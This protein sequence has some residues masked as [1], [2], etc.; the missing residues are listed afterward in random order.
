M[1]TSNDYRK[2]ITLLYKINFTR[3]LFS[4][5]LWLFHE[6]L[7]RS[8]GAYEK[9]VSRFRKIFAQRVLRGAVRKRGLR[10]DHEKRFRIGRRAGNA[11][12]DLREHGRG[13]GR[14]QALGFPFAVAALGRVVLPEGVQRG[15]A[16]QSAPWPKET[17]VPKFQQPRHV[18]IRR[19][20]SIPPRESGGDETIE[21]LRRRTAEEVGFRSGN[22]V[23][24]WL[25][26]VY[27]FF[28][29]LAVRP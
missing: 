6:T 17:F 27:P 29:L 9:L 28:N 5:Q 23:Y 16:R 25:V 18:Q 15:N 1:N 24:R 20:L 19:E 26:F 12:V 2:F 8:V 14:A 10:G 21:R 11:E 4:F 13:E 3:P 22:T 7:P